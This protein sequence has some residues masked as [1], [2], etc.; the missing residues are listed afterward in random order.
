[1]KNFIVAKLEEKNN[2]NLN[3]LFK[4]RNFDINIIP[5]SSEWLP[6]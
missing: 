2:Q 5:E 3:D 1:M 4:E 6:I